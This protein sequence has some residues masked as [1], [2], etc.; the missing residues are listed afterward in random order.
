ML[1]D[2]YP[3]IFI[4]KRKWEYNDISEDE[5]THV[6]ENSGYKFSRSIH[7]TIEQPDQPNSELYNIYN[8]GTKYVIM[9]LYEFRKDKQYKFFIRLLVLGDDNFIEYF[10]K[11]NGH[12]VSNIYEG[13]P[14]KMI[15]KKTFLKDIKEE[16]INNEHLEH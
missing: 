11:K 6:I 2:Y 5:I 7:S 10:G 9:D 4:T 16:L 15:R 3:E 13:N 8:E 14:I 12:F 1:P